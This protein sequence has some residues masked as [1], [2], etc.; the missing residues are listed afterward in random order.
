ML[1][2]KVIRQL[3]ESFD[4]KPKPGRDVSVSYKSDSQGMTAA[5]DISNTPSAIKGDLLP[6]IRRLKRNKLKKNRQLP[7]EK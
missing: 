4:L 7:K 2:N 3:L 6:S 1:F 5:V